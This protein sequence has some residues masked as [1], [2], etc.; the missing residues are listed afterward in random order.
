RA[1]WALPD[2]PLD[3]ADVRFEARA[4]ELLDEVAPGLA[5]RLLRFDRGHATL[6]M[7]DLGSPPEREGIAFLAQAQGGQARAAVATA[8]GVLA[9]LHAGLAER[10]PDLALRADGDRS[11]VERNLFERVGYHATP[12]SGR[13]VDAVRGLPRQLTLGDFSPKNVVFAEE[14]IRVLD[15]EHVHRG[16]RVF[17]LAFFLGH[18]ALHYPQLDALGDA[19][20]GAVEAY[21]SR[22]PLD[23]RSRE[24]LGPVAGA[25]VLYRVRNPVV[26]YPTSL[27]G[28]ARARLAGL[29]LEALEDGEVPLARVVALVAAARA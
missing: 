18:V 16:P 7:T 21:E 22:L 8:T 19:V 4:L 13:L 6:V 29:L 27:T 23:A 11:F 25:A 26:P 14:G 5:P 1:C 12:G 24:L 9:E 2:R 15:L 20:S 3:P 28:D 17:D 10:F